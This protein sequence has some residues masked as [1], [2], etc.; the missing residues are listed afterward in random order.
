MKTMLKIA[1]FVM[2]A[3]CVSEPGQSFAQKRPTVVVPIR[4]PAIPRLVLTCES[5]QL[6]RNLIQEHYNPD[7]LEPPDEYDDYLNSINGKPISFFGRVTG[8]SPDPDD[9]NGVVIHLQCGGVGYNAVL[10]YGVPREKTFNI[11]KGYYLEGNG[12]V[13]YEAEKGKPL[14]IKADKIYP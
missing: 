4:T 9:P 12:L 13:R 7:S 14:P 11:H 10:L 8:I 6:M 3:G 2:L 5:V 1:I